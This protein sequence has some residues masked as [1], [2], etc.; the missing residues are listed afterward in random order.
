MTIFQTAKTRYNYKYGGTICDKFMGNKRCFKQKQ[1]QLDREVEELV[2][3]VE[4]EEEADDD[5]D[6]IGEMEKSHG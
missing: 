1:K 4:E 3:R 2:T 5:D 6:G